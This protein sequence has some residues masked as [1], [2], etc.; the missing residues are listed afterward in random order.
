MIRRTISL[1]LALVFVTAGTPAYA[2]QDLNVGMAITPNT[3]PSFVSGDIRA[4][5][6]G[7]T[8]P[9]SPA[10]PGAQDL[11]TA[12]LGKSGLESAVPPG[13]VNPVAPTALELRQ[14]AIYTNY[15]ALLDPTAGGGYGTLY[16]PNVDK[17]G[18]VTASQGLIPG[19]EYLAYADDGSGRQNV[20][21]MVQV[22]DTFDLAN[23][24]IITATTSGSRGVYGAIG[25]AGEWGLKHGCAVAYADK[26][27]GN[28]LHDLMTDAVGLMRHSTSCTTTAG[29]L[30]ATCCTRRTIGSR[31]TRS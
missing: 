12:G 7:A 8:S 4:A 18:N 22:P 29:C 11:L 21:L 27:S 9:A 20:T 16:G 19:W 31:P 2:T 17:N 3:T 28:G 25:T 6:Y 13:F 1:A 10:N 14:R 23:A 15:R 5:R 26:G 24:C 30:T